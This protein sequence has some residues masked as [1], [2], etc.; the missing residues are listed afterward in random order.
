MEQLNEVVFQRKHLAGR[1]LAEKIFGTQTSRSMFPRVTAVTLF[2][3]VQHR[4]LSLD[5]LVLESASA[6]LPVVSVRLHWDETEQIVGQGDPEDAMMPGTAR[7]QHVFVAQAF[8]KTNLMDSNAFWGSTPKMVDRTTTECLW[9]AVAEAT[10]FG[11][12]S[13][14]PELPSAA[15]VVFVLIAD[16]ASSNKKLFKL[17]LKVS[18]GMRRKVLVF[19]QACLLHVLHRSLVPG[20][21]KNN[22]I[23]DLFRAAHS[24]RV[25]SYWVTL[26]KSCESSLERRLVILHNVDHADVHYQ[27]VA[28]QILELV[29]NVHA[30]AGDEKK[31]AATERIIEDVLA[32]FPGNWASDVVTYNCREPGC[33]G[34]AECKPRAMRAVMECVS[35]HAFGKRVTIPAMSRWWKVAPV[36]RQ[37]L[38]GTALHGL[39]PQAAP[40]KAQNAAEQAAPPNP[41]GQEDG[42]DNW[43][44]IHS[45]RVGKT[46][47]WFKRADTVSSLIV[48]LQSTR[49]AHRIM[50]WIMHHESMKEK[51]RIVQANVE[52]VHPIRSPI[53]QALAD[54]GQYLASRDPWCAAFAFHRGDPSELILKI[55]G[56]M[57]PAVS[58]IDNRLLGLLRG[59]L[60]LL[61]MCGGDRA[62]AAQVWMEFTN[63]SRC[64]VLDAW[65]EYWDAARAAGTCA[66]GL[67]AVVGELAS[68]WSFG[69]FAA[70]CINA[71]MRKF[72]QA[73]GGTFC[74][75]TA[76][77]E[78]FGAEIGSQHCANCTPS[79]ANKRGRPRNNGGNKRKRYCAWNA[80]VGHA[81]QEP[82][83]QYRISD[84]SRL[85]SL[86]AQWAKMSP[87]E[88]GVY[89]E[90]ALAKQAQLNGQ[91]DSGS[92]DLHG[93]PDASGDCPWSLGAGRDCPLSADL[94][95]T[96]TYSAG[97]QE[98]VDEWTAP[99]NQPLQHVQDWLHS[100][101]KHKKGQLA[102]S[103]NS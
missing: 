59:P 29:L 27:K 15:W 44:D 26:F 85:Q 31:A 37:M 41:M 7:R 56:T 101:Q 61:R 11:P 20:M 52:F 102:V 95:D 92:E 21:R 49:P 14:L 12:W 55:W 75:D 73:L 5:R 83:A 89:K 13:Q 96:P 74:F 69:N 66:P 64:C 33:D 91:S 39:W 79:V 24:L 40:K 22:I 17:A 65:R 97:L 34:G 60:K 48:L 81:P 2:R 9:R 87:E 3:Y 18:R 45:W 10:P 78:E 51:A 8:F 1:R 23:G 19:F 46:F 16:E 58:I 72:L 94:A 28:R 57:L 86:S 71:N 100:F 54:A 80:F 63:T 70:E 99:L 6:V 103:E 62:D 76:A 25:A 53:V 38:L 77:F 32:T 67:R 88:Q 4:K 50:A 42:V 93:V 36:A 35:K 30:L 47:D 43:Q 82:D 68:Q 98:R 84:G 90:I